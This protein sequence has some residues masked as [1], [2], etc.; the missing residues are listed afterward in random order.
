MI[1]A[2]SFGVRGMRIL[3]GLVLLVALLGWSAWFVICNVYEFAPALDPWALACGW[4]IALLGWAQSWRA[5]NRVRWG[6]GLCGLAASIGMYLLLIQRG[7][8]QGAA[9]LAL[10]AASA[11]VMVVARHGGTAARAGVRSG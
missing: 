3:G 4:L 5:G 9:L 10:L 7:V 6:W 2:G 11:V 8:G 1:A